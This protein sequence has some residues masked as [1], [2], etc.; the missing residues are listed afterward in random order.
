M[1]SF[2]LI[3]PDK[4]DLA[5]VNVCVHAYIYVHKACIHTYIHVVSGFLSNAWEN[6]QKKFPYFRSRTCPHTHYQHILKCNLLSRFLFLQ[7]PKVEIFLMPLEVAS[8]RQ[9]AMLM[10]I[11]EYKV[12]DRITMLMI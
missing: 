1:Q 11:Q 7:N 5:K 4:R 2:M 9:V 6:Y 8:W 12:E 3:K 10:T